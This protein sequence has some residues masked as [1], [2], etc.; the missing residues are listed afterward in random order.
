MTQDTLHAM[1][2][3]AQVEQ[4]LAAAGWHLPEVKAQ[5]AYAVAV[6]R[7]GVVWTAGQLSRTD[8]GILTGCA[9]GEADLPA[10]RKA[11]EVAVLR[12]IA[13]V[14]TVAHL[15]EVDQIL[16]LRGF[17]VATP[18]FQRH[19]QALDAASDILL[20]AFGPKVGVHARSAL[21]VSSLPS[22]GFVE[23]ELMVGIS[24]QR[25]PP[26]TPTGIA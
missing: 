1:S 17:V 5:G 14:R 16:C 11:C 6:V 20:Q 8:D 15:D 23:V 24:N 21:G 3:Q 25:P 13:A 10:V 4:R 12:A 7:D 19:S 22:G 2:G 18:A 26:A 9:H